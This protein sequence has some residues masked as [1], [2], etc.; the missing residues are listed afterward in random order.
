MAKTWS[1]DEVLLK[2]LLLLATGGDILDK[3]AI[4]I[5]VTR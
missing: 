2:L 5:F 1:S 4:K 3:N